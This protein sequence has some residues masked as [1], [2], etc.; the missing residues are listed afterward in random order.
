MAEP[1][2]FDSTLIR[3]GAEAATFSEISAFAQMIEQRPITTLLDDLAGIEF[4]SETKFQVARR[5]LQRRLKAME[6]PELAIVRAHLAALER[7]DPDAAA[8]LRLLL[9]PFAA[10]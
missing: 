5:T 9:G 8:R 1:P 3:R 7:S 10:E 2:S 6:T 4:L